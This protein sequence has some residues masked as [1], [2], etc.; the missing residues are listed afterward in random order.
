LDSEF[1][2]EETVDLFVEINSENPGRVDF[3]L[4]VIRVKDEHIFKSYEMSALLEKGLNPIMMSIPLKDFFYGDYIL[5][6]LAIERGSG[7]YSLVRLPFQV[8][9]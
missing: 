6:V 4:S 5:Q 9:P 3:Y 7:Q 2:P 1:G 8:I